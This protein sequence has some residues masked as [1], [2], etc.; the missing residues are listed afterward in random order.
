[1]R[2]Q[3]IQSCSSLYTITRAKA[4]TWEI[5]SKYWEN[6]LINGVLFSNQLIVLSAILPAGVTDHLTNSVP[7]LI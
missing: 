2:P 6:K 5:L 7:L 3:I 4:D 1:M